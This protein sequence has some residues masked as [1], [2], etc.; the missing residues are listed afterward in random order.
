MSLSPRW[1]LQGLTCLV[2]RVI[3]V[4]AWQSVDAICLCCLSNSSCVEVTGLQSLLKCG[5]WLECC[6]LSMPSPPTACAGPA[7]VQHAL[8]IVAEPDSQFV[9]TCVHFACY[10]LWPEVQSHPHDMQSC[11]FNCSMFCTCTWS[12]SPHSVVHSSSFRIFQE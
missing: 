9:Y 1:R 10:I 11:A 8:Y 2:A 3:E 12:G 5:R 4:T 7:C 6:D